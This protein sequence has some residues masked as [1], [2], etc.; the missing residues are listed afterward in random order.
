MN[1]QATE[2]RFMRKSL[3][4]LIVITGLAMQNVQAQEPVWTSGTPV[5]T[6]GPGRI[7]LDLSLN[8]PSTIYYIVLN[9]NVAGTITPWNC[10]TQ[11]LAGPGGNRV[12]TGILD[13][14]SG[15]LREYVLNLALNTEHTVFIVAEN[16]ATGTLQ[17]SVYKW[18]DFTQGCPEIQVTTGF[19]QTGECLPDVPVVF[20]AQLIPMVPSGILYGT[21][22]Q[23]DW[24]DGSPVETFTSQFDDDLPD[25]ADQFVHHYD[26]ID[27]ECNYIATFT[28]LNPCGK[29]SNGR[30]ILVVHGQDNEIDGEMEIQDPVSG[31]TEEVY[32]CE[33]TETVVTLWD[34]SIWNC[35]NPVLPLGL[36]TQPNDDPRWLQWDYGTLLNTIT[37]PVDIEGNTAPYTGAVNYPVTSIHTYAQSITIPASAIAG[38]RFRVELRNW[39]K[40]NPYGL[41]PYIATTIDIV[42]IDAPEG[43]MGPDYSRCENNIS[44]ATITLSATGGGGGSNFRY[45]VQ[46]PSG[47]NIVYNNVP[48][49]YT[50]NISSYLSVGQNKFKL[51]EV[52]RVPGNT[53]IQTGNIDST[54]IT[55]YQNVTTPTT[56]PD[57]TVCGTTYPNLGGNTPAVGTGSWTTRA[58]TGIVTNPS[59]PTSGVTNLSQGANTFRWTIV[60]GD[61][62]AYDEIT[63]TRDVQPSPANAG[64]NQNLCNS[65]TATM[66][67]TAV[68]N[69]GAGYWNVV[70]GQF[71][72]EDFNLA[73][74]TT[75]DAG[76][77]AW[78]RTI[79][80]GSPGYAEVR[81]KKFEASNIGSTREAIWTGTV[82]IATRTNVGIS[83]NLSSLSTSNGFESTD[84]VNIR[85]RVDGA[86]WTTIINRTGAA[87]G[88]TGGGSMAFRTRTFT[89]TG[90]PTGT[91]LEIQIRIRNSD[92]GEIYYIDN[93]FVGEGYTA[94]FPSINNTSS[95]TTTVSGLLQGPNVFRWTAISQYRVCDETYDEVTILRDVAPA[96]ANAG[97]DQHFCETTTA[98]MA[99]NTPTNNGTGLWTRTGGAGTI[100]T[101]S[102]PTTT[103]TGLGYNNNTFR[104]TISSQ[105]G[106]CPDDDDDVVITRYQQPTAASTGVDQD[107][108]GVLTSNSLGGNTPSVGTG[109]WSMTSGPGSITSINPN[110]NTPNATITVN[111]AGTYVFRWTIVNGDCSTYDE[112]QVTYRPAP[113]TANAGLNAST[114]GTAY[115][116]NGNNPTSGTGTWTQIA[117]PGTVTFDNPNQYNTTVRLAV[118]YTYGAYTFR[119]TIST[120]PACN[121]SDDVVITFSQGGEATANPVSN[122]C[123]SSTSLVNIPVSGTVGGTSTQGRWERVSGN[124]VFL[125]SGAANGSTYPAGVIND[126]YVPAAADVGTTVQLRL[127]AYD[128]DGGGS[129][130][131]EYSY[132]SFEIH[133]E[134][135]A[136]ATTDGTNTT[137]TEVCR[138]K[139]TPAAINLYG[140]ITSSTTG[141]WRVVTGGGV[142]GSSGTATGNTKT[143]PAITDTYIPQPA[144]VPGSVT[145]QLVAID[146]DGG[147]A[148]NPCASVT[149][150]ITIQLFEQP[151][152]NAGVDY[153]ICEAATIDVSGTIG[154]GASSGTWSV[155]NGSGSMG[156]STTVGNTV[157]AT[158]TLGATDRGNT[159]TLRL[160]T[161]DP[162][163][164]CTPVTDDV[165]ITIRQYPVITTHPPN[166]IICDN[167][168]TNFYVSVTGSSLTF[169]WQVDE[170][171]GF[172]NVVNGGIYNGATTINL[173]ITGATTAESGNNYRC[174]VTSAGL[175]STTSNAG[176][177]TVQAYP[178]ITLDPVDREICENGTTTFTVTA[179][180]TTLSYRWQVDTGSGFTNL[181]NGGSYSGVT[182]SILT[183]SNAPAS[184]DNYKYRCVVTES[185][186]C[187]TTSG[188]ATLTVYPY[189]SITE[190]P[191]ATATCNGGNASFVVTVSGTT[192]T[193]Q[194]QVNDGSG[195]SNISNSGVYSGALTNTLALT[196]VTLS[197]DDYM[198]RCVVT[199][200]ALCP[201]NTS[202]VVLDVHAYPTVTTQPVDGEICNGGNTSFFV[203]ATGN[204]LTYQWQ[205]NQGSGWVD[206]T[207]VGIYSGV[208]TN[209][210]TI[211][212]GTVLMNGYD[213]RCIVT[214]SGLCSTPSASANL[215]VRAYPPITAQPENR[216]ICE[217]GNTTFSVTATGTSLTYQWQ[218]NTGSGFN[219]ITDGGV[220]SNA[221]TSILSISGASMSYNNYAYRCLV[222][223]SNICTTTSAEATLT[224][225][226]YPVISTPP[227][228]D[229]VC[230]G[231]AAS[232]SVTATGTSLT[233]QWQVDQGGG[234]VSIPEGGFYS[235]TAS[236]TLTINPASVAINGYDYR[237]VVTSY[238]LCPVNSASA[239]LTVFS[240]PVITIQPADLTMCEFADSMLTINATGTTLTYQWQVDV[241]GT[242]TFTDINDGGVYLGAQTDTLQILSPTGTMNG[243]DYRCVVMESGA[244][245]TISNAVN[246]DIVPAPNTTDISG[247]LIRM[248]QG[249]NGQ[250]YSVDYHVGNTYTWTVSPATPI[251]GGGGTRSTNSY[252]VLNFPNPDT[253]TISVQEYAP[254]PAQ[255]PGP[256]KQLEVYVYAPPVADAG[257]DQ[258][259]CTG[260]S[261]VLGGTPNGVGPSATGGSGSYTFIWSPS[262]GLDDAGIEHPQASPNATRTY[263][264]FVDDNV[265]NCSLVQDQVTVN[266]Q[267]L[268]VVDAGSNGE[269]CQG[270]A[271]NL[272]SLTI[273]PGVTNY[274]SLLWTH[275]GTGSFDDPAQLTPVYTP[276][277]GE[278]GTVVMTLTATGIAP[279]GYVSDQTS[280]IITPAPQV[281]AG[282]DEET[283]EGEF[284]DLSTSATPPT[285][286]NYVT[287]TWTHNGT[288]SFNNS[289]ILTPTY[290]P[291]GGETGVVQLTMT[292]LG[293]GSCGTISDVMELTITPAPTVNAGSDEAV[294][295]EDPFDFSLK[296]TRPTATNYPSLQWT[297]NGLGTLN[298]DAILEPVYTPGVGDAGNITFTLTVN[299]N[300]VCDPVTDEFIL[301]IRP[302]PILS[303]SLNR[304]VCSD[305]VSG[306][307][308][309]VAPASIAA[310]SYNITDIRVDPGLTPDAGNAVPGNGQTA[311]AIYNDRFNNVTAT[312]LD[313]EY[314]VVPVSVAGCLGDMVTV[315]LTVN[316]EPV[317]DPDLDATVCSD[318]ASGIM[319]G[320]NGTSVAAATY[321]IIAI[322][323]AASLVAGGGNSSIGAGKAA[324]AI[325]GD[326][327]TNTTANALTVEY[328]VVPVSGAGCA[329]DL[330]T[331][332]LTVNPEPVL[333][334]NLNR[335][336]C[337]DVSSGIVLNTNG[338]SVAAASY[339]ITDIRVSGGLVAGA[340][341]AVAG[342]GQGANAIAGD[343]FTNTTANALTVEYDI[344]PVSGAGCTGDL[345][346]VVLTVNPEPVL[347]PGLDATVCSDVPS[348]IVLNT[349]GTSVSAVSYN[350]VAIRVD[351][352]LIAGA[353][354]ATTGTGRFAN[355]LVND[356]YTNTTAGALTA[357]YDIVPVS[358]SGCVGD[359]ET[360]VLTVNPEPVVDPD[361]DATVCS[362]EVSGIVLN[363]N[364]VSVAA[365]GYNITVIRVGSGLIAG[366]GNAVVGDGQGVNAIAGD[367]F[368]NTTANVLTV[369]YDIVPVSGAGCVG[370]TETVV[371]RVNPEPVLATNL[372]RSVCSDV[373]SGIVLNT[374]G[375]S[376]AAASYNIMDI[377]VGGGLIAGAGNAVA[378]NGQGANAIAGDIFTNTT[379]VALTVEYDVVPVSGAGCP[380]NQVTVVL[381]VNPEPVMDAGLDATVCSDDASGI[382]LNTNGVSVGA[383]SYNIT[384]I[385]RAGGLVAGGSNAT[386][387]T[388]KP[389]GAIQNDIYTNTTAVSL[390]V[391]YDVVPVSSAG[392]VG[393]METIV[394]TVN[395]EPV[396]ATNLNTA[397]CSDEVSGIVLNT[398]GVSV[399][400]ASYNIM[401]IRV[402]SGLV[403]GAGN[404]LVGNGQSADAIGGDIFTNTGASPRT[405]EYDIVPVS[406]D[407]CF[408]NQ[409]TVV[410]TVNPEPVLSP[411][412]DKTICSDVTT[413]IT[414]T[415]NGVSVGAASYTILDI[416][417]DGGLTA[418]AGNAVAGNG[419][420]ANAIA[421]DIFTNTT[422][423]ALTVEY[424]IIPVS[425]AGCEGD[426]VTVTVTVDPE[427]VLAAGLDGTVCSGEESGIVLNTDGVS[428]GASSYNIVDIRRSTGLTA[429]GS[430][431]GEGPGQAA[432]AIEGD[433]FTNKTA[434]ALTVEYDIIPVS[435]AGCAGDMETIVLTVNPE[436]VMATNLNATVCSDN[437]SGITLNTNGVSV[438]A[439][440]YNITEIRVSGGLTAG[441]GNAVV[442]DGQGANAIF[443]DVFTNQTASSLTVEYDVVPV[444]GEGC[445]G[446]MRTVILT[447]RPE[448]VLDPNLDATVCSDHVSGI[449][450]T[451]NGT[452]V[453]ASSY[454]ITAIRVD[455]GLVAGPANAV[456]GNNKSANAIVADIFTNTTAGALTAEYDI[457]PVSSAGC[458]GDQVTVTLTVNAEPVL[459]P[460]LDATVC[461][462]QPSGITLV[463][464]GL[465]VAADHYNI[466]DIRMD[467]GLVASP[468]NATE[469]NGKA[470]DAILNDVF[471]NTGA[472]TLTVEYDI[473]PVSADGCEGDKVTVT[474]TVDP[475][476]VMATNLNKSVCS[477][478]VSGII[479][480]TNGISVSADHYNITDIRVAPG[481]IPDAGNAVP[482]NG[483]S[484]NAIQGDIFNNITSG[485]LT[486]QYDVVPVS[487]D[488]CLGEMVTITLTIN[489]EPVLD[490]DL[491]TTVCSDDP[492]GI[493]LDVAAS[494][495]AAATY[496]IIAIN[497]AAGLVS[498][499]G[500]ATVG[501]GRSANAIENDVFT[502]KTST[503]LTVVYDIV[504]VSAVGCLGDMVQVTLTVNPEP[505]VA[506]DLNRTVCSDAPGGI[507]LNTDP[508]SVAAVNYNIVAIDVATGLVP[509]SGN[510]VEGDGQPASALASD[511]FT[512]TSGVALTVRYDVVPVSADNCAGDV[513]TVVLTVNPEPVLDPAL[514]K[515]VCSDVASG[516]NLKVASGSVAAS[517]YNITLITV[518]PSLV[519]ASGNAVAE[520]GLPANA[521]SADRFTNTTA[522]PLPVIYDV[523]PVSAAGCP[524]DLVQ[525]T[526]TVNPEPVLDP[527]L[528]TSVCSDQPSGIMLT[529]TGTSVAA[530]TYNI[531]LN[532]KGAGLIGAPTVGIG[533]TDNAIAGDAFTNRTALPGD[534]VYNVI[535]VSADGCL[536]NPVTVTLTVDPEPVLANNLNKVVCSR[537]SSGI[538]LSTA[539]GSVAAASY[540][541]LNINVDPALVPDPG[542][543]VAGN[544]LPADAIASD[545][546]INQTLGPL[547]V[548]YDVVPVSAVPCDGDLVQVTLTVNPEPVLDPVL[549][550]TVCSDVASGIILRVAAGSISASSYNIT[551]IMVDAGLSPAAGNVVAGN[552][553]SASAIAADKFT[554]LTTAAL[555]VVYDVVPVSAL[556]CTGDTSQI[557]LTVNP[558]PVLDPDLTTD[559]CSDLPSG[560]LLNV[561]TTSVPADSY[562][563]ASINMASGLVP[564]AGNA[565]AGSGLPSTAIA[566][567]L[568]TNKN[569]NS[570]DVV[571]TVVPVSA[572][573]CPGDPVP[574]TLTVN[575]EPVLSPALNKTVCSDATS[576]INLAVTATSVAA[577]HYNILAINVDIG[578]VAGPGNAVP[579]N[580]LAAG[581]IAGDVFTN[582]T[583]GALTVV[584]DIVPVSAEGCEGDMLQVVLTVNPEPVL[585]PGLSN[586]VCSDAASGIVLAVLGGSVPAANYNITG[587]D[588]PAGLVP[589]AGNATVGNGK[590]SNAIA[591]DRFTNTTNGDLVVV[592]DVVPVSSSGCLGDMVQVSLTINPEP[593]LDPGLNT[594][595]CSDMPSGIVLQTV[596]GSVAAHHYNIV[597]INV[598]FGLVADA[599]NA[600]VGNGQTADAISNDIFTNRTANPQTVAYR[601]IP[602]SDIG[603][604]G[605]AVT[606]TLTVNPEPVINP[607]L[608]R[609][610]CSDT[611]VGINLAVITG[612]VTAASYNIVDIR[613][614]PSLIPGA[615]NAVAGNGLASNAIA[616]DTFTN[617]T[618]F[619]AN[620][621]YDVVP[622]SALNCTG[623]MITIVVTVNPEPVVTPGLTQTVCSG[624]MT[625]LPV[626]T[627][628][629]VPGTTFA[630]AVPVNTGGMTGG[631]ST[632]SGL[633]INDIFTNTT[634][635]PQTATYTVIPKSGLGCYGDPQTVVITVNSNPVA[636]INGGVNTINVCGGNDLM[637]DG[638]PTGGSG[639]YVTH[640][641]TGNIGPLSS[642]NTQTTTF[643][644]VITGSY[645]LTYTVT[646]D[647]GCS[648]TDN[649]TVINDNP[650]AIFSM[651]A[652]SGCSA[653]T[654][655]FTNNS[656]GA[657]SYEWD[658]GDGSPADFNT[659]TTHTFS[660]F[661]TIIQYFFVTLYAESSNGCRDSMTHTVTVYP[662]VEAIFSVTEDTLCS[663]ENVTFVADPGGTSYE[664][665]FGD[666]STIPGS[667]VIDHTYNNLGSTPV[668]YH[669]QLITS[670]FFTCSD[671]AEMDIVVYPQ[672]SAIFLPIPN[673]ASILDATITM[674]NMTLGTGWQYDWDFGDSGSSTEFEPSHT[675][676][677]PGAFT[678]TLTVSNEEC[679]DATTQVVN[680]TPEPPV[681]SFDPVTNGCMPWTI[682]FNNTSLYGTSY[683][684]DFGN[685]AVSNAENPTYT[686]YQAGTFK[687]TL[688][689]IGPGGT[690]QTSQTIEVYQKP[691]AYFIVTP[692]FVYVN[693]EEVKCLNQSLYGDHYLW[694]FGDS[695]TDTVFEPFHKYMEA[696]VYDISL[697]VTTDEGCTDQYILSPAVTVEPAGELRF[698]NA[699][700]PNTNGPRG[701]EPPSTPDEYNQVFFPPIQEK[702][703]EYHLQIFNRWGEMIF[704][705]FDINWGWDGYYK[706]TLCKQDVYIW[707]VTGKYSNGKPFAKAG[708]LTLLR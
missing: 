472:T 651:D 96:A 220:Y 312:P 478:G 161:N 69:G 112:I 78:T 95:P 217:N 687:I 36:P 23:V 634:G 321:N 392:C 100:T 459:D 614:D 254:A 256:I 84:Y 241:A 109:T 670:S 454:T 39:N 479:L 260:G 283:C 650:R 336:V 332:V 703:D 508:S 71:W 486:V 58:G 291:G 357:E 571:Y 681:P 340:G 689:V 630:W 644:S 448:P 567:D 219:N 447:V 99:A 429:G 231:Q 660:N 249:T 579:G 606:I 4:M 274:T 546:F 235:G 655:D 512:N 270:V 278:T 566:G 103:I 227:V 411:S 580:N 549:D 127:R 286:S 412:L 664:W 562:T 79:S 26:A 93:V 613:M 92:A 133:R 622:V 25:G 277:A 131:D 183:I 665:I 180:G 261:A 506:S 395:P 306:I 504:P 266:V 513:K 20:V 696:G 265:S 308:L 390:T 305:A 158:Y 324:D 702:V 372:N 638:S 167:G 243:Y 116:L 179:T 406:G 140:R 616:N 598:G 530:A 609:S 428:V 323:K 193:Y 391:E 35:Q 371:L 452:S 414:L 398:N 76:P 267:P 539:T 280:L 594:A 80:G 160:S 3:L 181:S 238:G 626:T 335:S 211:T 633:I 494:S 233:Y 353:G 236:N 386:V 214:E 60:N 125:S 333:A 301:S 645:A 376:V 358:S 18:V 37:G 675:Y 75:T 462:N 385:R 363:T 197:Y 618:S 213:Y 671:T 11:A 149:D 507:L 369:E 298:N 185:V 584:Y 441:A 591:S 47:G 635:L 422:A 439:A 351:A 111:T 692:T 667:N 88:S 32:V 94:A 705:S 48:S 191:V 404:A 674:D 416:R 327:F 105:Y 151:T 495:V 53:C 7:V 477:D 29:S 407:G 677:N 631:T 40:C 162:V 379:A 170:G 50:P 697:T 28:A 325:A 649:V 210:M 81:N 189:P 455:A 56:G 575:P 535:P 15:I 475:E 34:N 641:W 451:T 621:E 272:A 206:L 355:A 460:G 397:V 344:I 662:T 310:A 572:E 628:N 420:A 282:S 107:L 299:G 364:G 12:A 198:Y 471:T 154:G 476:P 6:P 74:G 146:P 130:T 417:V 573:G 563:I 300:G 600:G 699:F 413:G 686:Y 435:G 583:A 342:N 496:N 337:S 578:L 419:Q 138:V 464:N 119:W 382:V 423:G 403:S 511:I 2:Q 627:V 652:S 45:V 203:V 695:H 377:R 654:V 311:T 297:H 450:L 707:R 582:T 251:A 315:V 623:D 205:E 604:E 166:R 13:Y 443:N 499:A 159:I 574:V 559:V 430:N 704:E 82:N 473:I 147:G 309:G 361:L 258:T 588:V 343:I 66:A 145:L 90:I 387:G 620:V 209:T 548:V 49:P 669:V 172:I 98:T 129:C 346:T 542:N 388:G 617:V 561:S 331:V 679:F 659:N 525:I 72:L 577:D 177:L 97:L 466:A 554:N 555:T 445:E 326:I 264:L 17:T 117:G 290:Y 21:V 329:G 457:V 570:R 287:V 673:T 550:R 493:V 289:N 318:I 581:A 52:Q 208:T 370:N 415:T 178:V 188:E 232:F 124:G 693:D 688:T 700:R 164:P 401:A 14:N 354:N 115:V 320:T 152:V 204:F 375:V 553:Y 678:I 91:T 73:D 51:I 684:W 526:L 367:I 276:G 108:C 218:E 592:Y 663:G 182:T 409:V 349:N 239:N 469:G 30:K 102:S 394:L 552:G 463:T 22:W 268:P 139:A 216:T 442:G 330:E 424:D 65:T 134:A 421:G 118:P 515:S 303:P 362:D 77:T 436:P 519:P 41:E 136:D 516:L 640:Q 224:V 141:Y 540:N 538:L 564:A 534:V 647:N 536:G 576:G 221:T 222:T 212:G 341:N 408:G 501:I 661:T 482:G 334:T 537:A 438:A 157:T 543:A 169:Q 46:R 10:R 271:F 225:R 86:G 262:V 350:L 365:A 393:D 668:T 338:V 245:P 467:G 656:I 247:G 123:M 599:G 593:V 313:V 505:V 121:S 431:A 603:C 615:G 61:C 104:W 551:N 259:I 682:Q 275:N 532:S 168:S 201:I 637:L 55:V 418:G 110:A 440:G 701:G 468:T 541:I 625:N 165:D 444:S 196:G 528:S 434:G 487:A 611:P 456:P 492:S 568:F 470:A 248:C 356:V 348:G 520:N 83:V 42:I 307:T 171:S 480:N 410:L 610:A 223:E 619:A 288:G 64:I 279:C 229:V 657:V 150:D 685:G 666:G 246:L 458:L 143:G 293:N 89:A 383:A 601:V 113:T 373:S 585:N 253:Y 242:G 514:D 607:S 636:S 173:T 273:Q 126:T 529:T 352:G 400:A 639:N 449:V 646:D 490:P 200:S 629:S 602:V 518:D 433:I 461:S 437:I 491:S 38:E 597:S 57:A 672:P 608:S 642:I 281:D 234:F 114:C 453:A 521:L 345:R 698:A 68:N 708:D 59:S 389:A 144:D 426:M 691:N 186:L 339:N 250:F 285:A 347:D 240:Y 284:F 237:C 319:L 322:R 294:C 359:M 590:A 195:W 503:A 1:N 595:V 317:L 187:S 380:G 226:A 402:Q 132:V 255:C 228:D 296:S 184:F 489:P 106:I 517:S 302:E 316:P 155:V 314:D 207:D 485:S 27:D 683:I 558:E 432:G 135:T 658:F 378:G 230:D 202:E 545:V 502:N 557:T 142:I 101:P 176:L 446:E 509:A 54:I 399:A 565:I 5:V 174:I 425:G 569:N 269:T 612:S 70:S 527:G 153:A 483:Q 488:N 215:I 680:I 427:P 62:V 556:G 547:T 531:T 156:L 16:K 328:D 175:C 9:Y 544:N 605:D 24:G 498:K 31:A 257:T 497:K 263:T 368:T 190:Q 44:S 500:N 366:A 252:I 481:L 706:G 137:E 19:F 474:L 596:A 522:G 524:G 374:N 120:G 396:L 560:I 484:A 304:T 384:D 533:L 381:T 465:S 33:G 192:L 163:G 589:A 43:A 122:Y 85:Y 624:L 194:W 632:S 405:V 587:I 199:E 87:D 67:A 523:V 690:R 148:D 292:V 295:G 586:A 510:A 128:P 244:C 694:D 648:G 360:V 8:M 643:N 63:I 653:L 676:T